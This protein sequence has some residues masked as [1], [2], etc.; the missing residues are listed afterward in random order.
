MHPEIMRRIAAEHIKDLFAAAERWPQ[1][2]PARL[3]PAAGQH[4][5]A[6]RPAPAGSS[7][8]PARREEMTL[9]GRA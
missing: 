1:C 7:Q 6:I 5:R 3:V 8:S 4:A 9:R 2:R